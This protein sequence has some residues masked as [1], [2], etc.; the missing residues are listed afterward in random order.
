MTT[1]SKNW[2]AAVVL[3]ETPAY[4]GSAA[5]LAADQQYDF[6]GDVDLETDGQMGAQVLIESKRTVTAAIDP[7]HPTGLVVD[8]FASLDGTVYDT[9]PFASHRLSSKNDIEQFSFVVMEVAHFR[10]GLKTTGT[11]GTFDYQITHQ[12]WN[13]DDS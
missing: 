6:S 8:V 5:V 9:I 4:G 7:Q 10:L 11:N 2:A 3:V 12:R 13:L 1:V